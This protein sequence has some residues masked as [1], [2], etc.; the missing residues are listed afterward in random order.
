M[1]VSMIQSNWLGF[2]SGITVPGWGINL[3]NRGNFFSLDPAHANVIAPRK[4]TLHTLIPAMALRDGVPWL[5]FGSM[6]GDG[7]AQ[8]HVQLLARIVDD[9]EDIQRAIDAPR[10]LVSPKDW[11]VRADQRFDQATLESLRSRGHRVDTDRWF[12]PMFGHAHAIRVG[13]EGY[14]GATDPRTEGAVLGL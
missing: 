4:R 3:H 12:D 1:L 6:G 14:A 9:G 11:S 8:N 7:Q 13:D 2:G 5:V 10:W